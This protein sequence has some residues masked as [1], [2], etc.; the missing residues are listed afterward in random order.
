M[1]IQEKALY[2]GYANG[3]YAPDGYAK[4]VDAGKGYYN[5]GYIYA[6]CRLGYDVVLLCT[7]FL[8]HLMFCIGVC[9]PF[10]N[11]LAL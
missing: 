7:Y 3:D 10:R 1:I 2:D 8:E 9:S 5:D 6:S 4:D 11:D